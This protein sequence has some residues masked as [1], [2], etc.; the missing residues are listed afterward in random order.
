VD[1]VFKIV[2]EGVVTA[3]DCNDK[4]CKLQFLTK[5]ENGGLKLFDV[6]VEGAKEQDL[7]KFLNKFVRLEDLQIVQ[8]EFNKYYKVN[9]I[10]QIK[11]VEGGAKK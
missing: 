9:D 7:Q 4:S 6:K 8:I 11:V 5:K 2:G 10:S 1:G 3:I